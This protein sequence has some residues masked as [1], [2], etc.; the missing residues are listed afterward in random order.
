MGTTIYP[1]PPEYVLNSSYMHFGAFWEI[2]NIS[3]F[4][5]LLI[6]CYM[7]YGKYMAIKIY[8]IGMIYGLVLENAGP[9]YIPELGLHGYFWEHHYMFY[10]FQINIGDLSTGIRL[11]Q[12]PIATHFGW[13]NVFFISYIWYE[14]MVKAYPELIEGKIKPILFG[15][16]IM[17][18]SG[19]LRDLHLDPI[20][21][22][23]KWWIWNENL[24]EAWYGVPLINYNAWF[25]AVGCFGAFWVWVH[26]RQKNGSLLS[27]KEQTILLAKCLPLIW[28]ADFIFGMTATEIFNLFGLVWSVPPH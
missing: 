5:I 16:L 4:I 22:R 25:W 7:K 12:V 15:F 27:E 11:S 24:Y 3:M 26:R 9:L 8:L 17:T 18:T 19:L 13:S 14:Q 21:T 23:F 1:S 6:Y 10:F 2:F 28:F 20:A